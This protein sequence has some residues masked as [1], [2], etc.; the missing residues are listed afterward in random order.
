MINTLTLVT[1]LIIDVVCSQNLEL[2][3]KKSGLELQILEADL[4]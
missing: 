1:L 2:Q 4:R 3:I